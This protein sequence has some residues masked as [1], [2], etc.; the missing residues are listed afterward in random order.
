MKSE[1][2]IKNIIVS[3]LVF[4]TLWFGVR[5][6]IT[7]TSFERFLKTNRK[8]LDF[9][10]DEYAVIVVGS[11]PEGI[12]SALA[13][14]RTGLKTLLITRDSHL[15]SYIK[16]GMISKMNPERGIIKNKKVDLNR[17][18]YEELFGKFSLGFSS[19]DYETQIKK[20]IEKE[21]SLD[22]IYDSHITDVIVENRRVRA[23]EVQQ[24]DGSRTYRARNFIDATWDGELLI[25]CNTPYISGSEDVGLPGF[26]APVEFNF[27][28]S[29]VD[30]QALKKSQKTTDFIDE[31]QMALLSYQN[32]NPRTKILSPSFII[33]NESELVITGLQVYGVDISDENDLK[34]ARMEAEDEAI[35]LTS[36]LKN[37]V[38]AFKDCTYKEGSENFFIPE[39]RHFEGRYLLTV[40]DIL[41]NRDFKDKIA[42]CSEAVDAG[43]FVN[44]NIEYIVAK[45][46]VYSIP[47]GSV[48]PSN[49]DNVFMTGAK[50]SFTSLASTSAGSIPT[51]ITVGE[52]AGLIATYSFLNDIDPA[53]MLNFSDNDFKKLRRFLSRGGIYLEDFSESIMIPETEEKLTDLPAYP[54]ISVLA[55]YGLISGGY[56]NDFKLDMQVTEEVFSVLVKNTILKMAPEMYTMKTERSLEAFETKDILTGEKAGEIILTVMSETWEKGKALETLKGRKV[57]PASIV[58]GM[59]PGKPVT[60]DI[61][62]GL[63]VETARVLKSQ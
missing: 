54:Y 5:P 63:A 36:Y 45:P 9:G 8:D 43:K 52:A 4:L 3:I 46:N 61:V 27:S 31:F 48:I 6:I 1:R 13:S 10:E 53:E 34:N 62:Y 14:A 56:E 23:I 58:N 51:R 15:G 57:L 32:E 44:R 41:E 2:V 24:K 26:Y 60:M 12:A 22:V 55:E 25:K 49:L 21:E 59:E 50:A 42:L 11:E 17:G 35:M 29:G 30:T 39:Y 18:I 19:K 38:I 28:I 37:L 33:L 40:K 16:S 20:L 7:G 47:L